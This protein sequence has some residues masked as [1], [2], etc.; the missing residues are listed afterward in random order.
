ML[1]C[2]LYVASISKQAIK[3][4]IK[5]NYGFEITD[6]GAAAMARMIE[7]KAMIVSK[8]AV[9]NAKKD[10]RKEVTRRDLLA[11]AQKVGFDDA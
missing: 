11:Y 2:G 9:K 10:K 6:D 3:D 5:R 7:K 4:L 8:F 1:I